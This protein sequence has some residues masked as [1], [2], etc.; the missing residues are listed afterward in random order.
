MVPV[1]RR[2]PLCLK[3]KEAPTKQM[4]MTTLVR[5]VTNENF[6]PSVPDVRNTNGNPADE[7][8]P[9]IIFWGRFATTNTTIRRVSIQYFMRQ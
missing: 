4:R 5:N 9:K 3:H 6:D 2:V 7:A 8:V 1:L